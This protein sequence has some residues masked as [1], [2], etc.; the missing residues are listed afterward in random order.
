MAIQCKY[1]GTELPKDDA[2]FCNNCGMLVPSHPFSPQ[3]LSALK[4]AASSSSTEAVQGERKR[5]LH[6]QVAELSPVRSEQKMPVKRKMPMESPVVP[7]AKPLEREVLNPTQLSALPDV[8]GETPLEKLPETPKPEHSPKRTVSPSGTA[9]KQVT[10]RQLGGARRRMQGGAQ[11]S[12]TAAWPE[13]ITHVAAREPAI[14]ENTS[15]E[16]QKETPPAPAL[17][18]AKAPAAREFHIAV[19]EDEEMRDLSGEEAQA[20][21]ELPTRAIVVPIVEDVPTQTVAARVEDV[22][23]LTED[24]PV[25]DVPTQAVNVPVE[26]VPTQHLAV[27]PEN[28]VSVQETSVERMPA[29]PFL[30]APSTQVAAQEKGVEDW[31]GHSN[32][33]NPAFPPAQSNVARFASSPGY[34]P[35]PSISAPEKEMP[36]ATTPVRRSRKRWP[37]VVV[38]LLLVVLAAGGVGALVVLSQRSVADPLLQ[39]QVSFRDT[40]LGL[41]LLYP[42]GWIKQVETAKS[43]AH[44]Y[45]SEHIGQIDVIVVSGGGDA[46]QAL[47]QQATKMGMSGTKAGVPLTF[48]GASWQ[49]LQGTMQVSGAK[50]TD[51]LLATVHGDKLFLIV[52]QAPQNNY[53][54]WDKE[55]FVPLR[56]S[57]KFI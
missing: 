9:Y 12:P 33:A 56:A 29:S 53:G 22:S 18:Q 1:C 23:N 11:I 41:S 51:M 21:E 4:N 52:Q 38:L 46:K 55:F 40:Q 34:E 31:Q 20:I 45:A 5:V 39:P 57:F 42:N 43:T 27:P 15:L 49:Q 19:W 35:A 54:D 16:E 26:D 47:Q 2:R 28:R 36:L 7:D 37:I 50:Y 30:S 44:F 14:V 3:S 6:E 32:A 13:P 24:V 48:A 17:P 25:E 8:Q 10:P